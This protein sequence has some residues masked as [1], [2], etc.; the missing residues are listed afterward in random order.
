MALALARVLCERIR[1]FVGL[2]H[3]EC[4]VVEAEK[5]PMNRSLYPANWEAIA[6]EVKDRA[7]WRCEECGKPCRRPGVKWDDFVGDL[8]TNDPGDWHEKTCDEVNG[9]LVQKPQRFTLT[10]AH[11]DHNPENCTEG[12][13]KALCSVCHLR[14]DKDLHRNNRAASKAKKLEATG[15]LTLLA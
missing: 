7:N 8:L 14:Y 3:H 6:F 15:Q 9:E 4:E 13:L 2:A 5:M 10:T 12:N 1:D 11:M